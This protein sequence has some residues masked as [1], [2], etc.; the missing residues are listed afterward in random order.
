MLS[1]AGIVGIEAAK[2]LYSDWERS[3]HS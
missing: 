2:A 3:I 1:M